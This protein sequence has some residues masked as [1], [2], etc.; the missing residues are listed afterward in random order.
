MGTVNTRSLAEEILRLVGGEENLAKA[1]HCATRLRLTLHDESQADT[2]ALENLQG[3]LAVVQA[4]G[5]YQVVVGNDVPTVYRELQRQAGRRTPEEGDDGDPGEDA[6]K[7]GS[8]GNLLNRF[9]D[10]ISSIIQPIVWTLAATG[11]LKA[12]LMMA[13]HFGWL[14]VEGDTYAILDVASDALFYF[15]PMFLAVTAARRFGTNQFTS[16]AIAGALV[17]PSVIDM[18]AEGEPVSFAGIPVLIMDYTYS[19]IPVVVAVWLQGYLERFLDRVLPAL[20]RSFTT[21][22][23]TVVVMVPLV[24]MTVGPATIYSSLA[25]SDS[26]NA[27]FDVAPWLA[28][29]ILGATY[30]VLVIFGLHWGLDPIMLSEL[31]T[32]GYSQLMGPLV[33]PVFAQAAATLAVLIRTRN[34]ARRKV[35]GPAAFSGFMAGITEPAI[36]GVNLP[37]KTPFYFGLIGGAV[38]GAI[39]A[40]GGSASTAYVFFNVLSLPAYATVGSFPIFLAGLAAAVLIS[41][42]LTFFFGPREEQEAAGVAPPEAG[43]TA[44]EDS[45]SGDVGESS[46]RSTQIL[47]PVAG[48][49]IALEDVK[50]KVFASGVMGRGAA[51]LPEEGHI[52]APVSGTVHAAME[53]GHAYGIRTDE[54]VEV[55]VHVGIDTVQLEGRGFT[56]AVSRGDRVKAGD[57]LVTVD[58]GVLS[59]AG[60]DPT[61]V[62]VVTN[63]DQFQ[64][65]LPAQPGRVSRGSAVITVH[66]V[67]AR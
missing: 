21:P 37:L 10:L 8:K 11:L 26:V 57:L 22:L 34:S 5:Q 19:L 1:T 23:L 52:C 13:G 16:M 41:F 62:L 38:G 7:G 43:S 28:G 60:Y 25:L 40:V 66:E 54:G 59:E 30:Q 14:D 58:F 39:A 50:D 20:I 55:L 42:T 35:A 6:Q 33:A 27:I 67:G 53:A 29:A 64:D 48:E 24:L 47:S 65:V 61:T 9:I 31:G 44:A 15:L 4:G 56:P 2:A 17:Y 46:G 49:T 18:A 45:L 51:I 12:F 36:Y 3:V 63:G 32:Y